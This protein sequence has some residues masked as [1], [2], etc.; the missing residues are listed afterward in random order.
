MA[1][2]WLPGAESA[3]QTEQVR[4]WRACHAAWQAW[5]RWRQGRQPWWAA[6]APRRGPA[7][8]SQLALLSLEQLALQPLLSLLSLLAAQL[9]SLPPA[10]MRR[11]A[12]ASVLR[13]L[14]GGAV[15]PPS[16]CPGLAHRAC[17]VSRPQAFA[18]A[19]AWS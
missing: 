18:P 8:L 9:L 10:P 13:R 19:A 7:F 6:R 4:D 14:C 11:G 15:R 5:R 2:G 1:W 3:A 17:H 16:P 12:V